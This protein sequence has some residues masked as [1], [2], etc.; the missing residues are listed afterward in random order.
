[1]QQIA[2][3]SRPRTPRL[4]QPQVPVHSPSSMTAAPEPFPAFFTATFFTA[5]FEDGRQPYDY[6]SRLAAAPCESRLI[7]IPTGLGKNK[8]PNP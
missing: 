2:R 8:G 5:A 1:M 4:A 7:S 6:Q 3:I